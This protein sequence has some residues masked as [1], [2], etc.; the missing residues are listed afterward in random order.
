[1][2]GAQPGFCW[3]PS[4]CSGGA[5]P[6]RGNLCYMER[7]QVSVRCLRC[8]PAGL[9]HPVLSSLFPGRARQQFL[10]CSSSLC[11]GRTGPLQSL[12]VLPQSPGAPIRV[13]GYLAKARAAAWPCLS[14]IGLRFSERSEARAPL[15]GIA[16]R[17]LLAVSLSGRMSAPAF[18]AKQKNEAA[19]CRLRDRQKTL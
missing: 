16:R 19:T 2:F 17:P 6:P 13:L 3:L 11:C 14:P 7:S 8:A 4:L 9:F 10:F 12:F 15:T 18:E 1:L 5:A